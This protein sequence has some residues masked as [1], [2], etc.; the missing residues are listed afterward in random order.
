MTLLALTQPQL[1]TVKRSDLRQHQ[2]ATL[3][4]AKGLTV[5]RISASSDE[6]E[7]LVIDKEYFDELLAKLRA[8]VETLEITLDKRLF[9]RI[10]AVE[11][12]LDE[13]IR[14]GRL[15]SFEEAFGEE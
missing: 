2:R 12:T 15:S 5:V 4:R 9:P 1:V 11:R 8:A 14:L 7:K 3:K 10:L 13:D 6:D